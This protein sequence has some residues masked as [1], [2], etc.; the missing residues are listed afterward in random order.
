MAI[1]L[2]TVYVC[3]Y[4]NKY[5]IIYA[6]MMVFS[7]KDILFLITLYGSET[8]VSLIRQ[9]L[10]MTVVDFKNRK[11]TYSFLCPVASI[12]AFSSWV[13]VNLA[14]TNRNQFDAL[15]SCLYQC[16]GQAFNAV[17]ACMIRYTTKN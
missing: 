10:V 8:M 4:N 12:T 5:V 15:H 17:A 16:E 1:T 3:L 6:I 7:C 9:I 2:Y 11:G 13:P 14:H